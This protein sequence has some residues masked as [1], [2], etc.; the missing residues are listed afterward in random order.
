MEI[1]DNLNINFGQTINENSK[2]LNEKPYKNFNQNFNQK[3]NEEMNKLMNQFNKCNNQSDKK[4]DDFI[5]NMDV[6]NNEESDKESDEDI[7]DYDEEYD[8]ELDNRYE[9]LEIIHMSTYSDNLNVSQSSEELKNTNLDNSNNFDSPPRSPK[10]TLT[11][12]EPPNQKQIYIS[13][14]KVRLIEKS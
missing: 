1:H 6:E 13:Q 4:S 9:I 2:F 8:E 5:D 10:R 12:R 11:D 3:F 7:E 14:R